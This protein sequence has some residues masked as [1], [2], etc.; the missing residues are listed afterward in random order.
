M[1]ELR[2]ELMQKFAVELRVSAP[3]LTEHE[4]ALISWARAGLGT[5][6][7][8]DPAPLPTQRGRHRAGEES[9]GSDEAAVLGPA[10]AWARPAY[11]GQRG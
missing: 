9:G 2:I 10:N 3:C 8:L 5:L 7:C 1:S 11:A 6:T 4:I